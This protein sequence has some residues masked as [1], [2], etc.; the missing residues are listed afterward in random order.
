MRQKTDGFGLV[1]WMIGLV[2]GSCLLAL[3]GRYHVSISQHAH[4]TQQLSAQTMDRLM[5]T[6]LIRTSIQQAGFTPCGA[7]EKLNITPTIRPIETQSNLLKIA[8]MSE[9]FSIA[10]H[11]ENTHHLLVENDIPFKAGETVLIADCF[12]AEIQ[13]IQSIHH[14]KQ[15]TELLFK[16][17]LHQ[18]YLP[19]IYIGEWLQER[20]FIQ[21]TPQGKTALYY[22]LQQAEVLS[23]HVQSMS[24]AWQHLSPNRLIQITLQGDKGGSWLIDAAPRA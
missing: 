19:P 24:I 11:M 13:T 17:P 9:Y 23:E 10:T 8:R 3:A 2:I 15:R 21:N 22:Q 14:D 18:S 16:T 12:Q 7:I 1:E 4:Q 5:I 20:F 6:D